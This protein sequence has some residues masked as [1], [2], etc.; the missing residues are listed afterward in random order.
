MTTSFAVP[1]Y[2]RVAETLRGRIRDGLYRVGDCI[3]TAAEL[4]AIFGV[5]S[6]TVRK[7]LEVMRNE[8]LVEGRRG[9]GTVVLR[10]AEMRKVDV[11]I[12]GNFTD[13]FDTA[14]AKGRSYEQRLLSVGLI[15]GP[16]R[17]CERFGVES[18]SAIWR[19]ERTRH[20]GRKPMS[21]H[22]NFAPAEFSGMLDVAEIECGGSFV[23]QLKRCHKGNLARL[24]QR[25][26]AATADI[27]IARLLKV[28]FGAPIFSVEVDYLSKHGDVLAVTYLYLRADMYSYS[29]SISI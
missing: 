7:A 21:Y 6:I 19:M 22:V 3:P 2:Q 27:D 26:D 5:S 12:S 9:V 10:A 25:V 20:L 18:Y 11:K 17:I 14:S 23:E 1:Q 4:E 28:E 13:W 8:G 24:D 15:Q 16:P 29:A